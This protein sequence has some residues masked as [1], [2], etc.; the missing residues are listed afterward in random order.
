MRDSAIMN[1][2]QSQRRLAN[3]FARQAQRQ[4]SHFIDQEKQV[5]AVNVFLHDERP[6]IERAGIEDRRQVRALSQAGGLG[7]RHIIGRG[8]GGASQSGRNRRNVTGW[9]SAGCRAL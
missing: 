3:V 4:R 8:I 5:A 7:S 9:S 2:L 1:R 6:G